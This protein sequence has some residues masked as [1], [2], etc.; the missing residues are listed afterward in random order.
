MEGKEREKSAN[1][2]KP[3]GVG[4]RPRS[5][6][7]EGERTILERDYYLTQRD[8]FRALEEEGSF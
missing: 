2:A 3:L 4:L 6:L 1:L 8:S 7:E 5:A